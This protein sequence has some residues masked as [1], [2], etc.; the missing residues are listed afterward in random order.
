MHDQPWQL[1]LV[2]TDIQAV[3]LHADVLFDL[4]D[5]RGPGSRRQAKVTGEASQY[6]EQLGGGCNTHRSL[7]PKPHLQC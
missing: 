5:E 6:T 4:T 1:Q 2:T 7:G 3:D